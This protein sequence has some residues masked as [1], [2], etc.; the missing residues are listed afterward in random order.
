[1]SQGASRSLSPDFLGYNN[2]AGTTVM[3]NAAFAPALQQLDPETLRGPVG[4]TA[5]DYLNWQTGQYFITSNTVPFI[6]PGQPNPAYQLSDY[7]NAL[8]DVHANAIFNVNVMTYCPVSNTNPASTSAAGVSCTQAQACGPV[9]SNYTTSCTN[10]DETWG[11]NFQIAMLKQAQSMGVPIKYI[12]LG[13]E[14]SNGG[15]D[16]HYYFPSAQSYINKVNA[17]IPV[18]KADFPGTQIAIVGAS[19]GIC[20]QGLNFTQNGAGTIAW[21]QAIGSQVQGENAIVF[22]TYYTSN[23]TPGGSVANAPDLSTMLSTGTQTCYKNLQSQDLPYLPSGVS[24][25]VTEWNLW[26]DTT[27]VE[28]GSWAQGLTQADYALDLV[29]LPQVSLTD[30]H[31]LVGGSGQVYGAL[32]PN[33]SSYKTTAEAGKIIGAPS[34]L[35]TTQALGMSGGGFVLGALERSL[36]GATNTT[37]LTFSSTP[38]VAGTSVPALMGQSFTVSGKTNLYFVNTSAGSETLSLGSL[39]GNYSVLQYASD[40]ANFITGNSSIPANTST[41]TNSITLPAYSVTSLVGTSSSGATPPTVSLTTPASGATISGT[42]TVTAS[43]ADSVGVKSV[44]FELDGKPLGAAVTTPTSGSTYTSTWNTTTATSASHTLAAVATDTSGTTATATNVTVTV[45]NPDTTPPSAP[46]SLMATAPTS[47]EVSLSWNASTDNVGVT[48]YKIYRA[49]PGQS[50]TLL[51]TIP[52]PTGSPVPYIDAAVSAATHYSYAVAALDAAGNQSTQSSAVVV[53]TP[54]NPDHTPPSVPKNLSGQAIGQTSIT[55]SWSA[56]S[57][58]GGSGLA[59]YHVYRDGMLVASPSSPTYT[60]T[61]LTP[62]TKYTYQVSAYDHAANGS[63]TS[64]SVKVVTQGSSPDHTPPT[65]P[66]NLHVIQKNKTK[67]S[68]T[69][70]WNASSDSGGSGLAGYNVYRDG[71]AVG[72]PTTT[73]YT[74]TGLSAG[75]AYTYYVKAVDNAGNLSGYRRTLTVTTKHPW[76]EVWYLGN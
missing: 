8:K 20:Q 19:G 44:Q 68:L 26:S 73:S 3:N 16:Y 6:K 35:P 5:A 37:T 12:E 2:D 21:N 15:A 29:R 30:A 52:A 45:K 7:I 58:T 54:A 65:S 41:A 40:P 43:A 59:G 50:L 64:S 22:H 38:D 28:H 51:T 14:V 71:V 63:K 36:H 62:G 25:W 47:A 57:D 23:I 60:D 67:T 61:G 33:A 39:S 69:L 27:Q 24:A 72:S 75:T 11:L 53:A 66:A 74:D 9:P 17:W 70:A 48:E 56:S 76:W 4:G 1:V 10:T 42:A 13:N 46:T 18:L 34:P 49:A 31:D 32:F 55:L